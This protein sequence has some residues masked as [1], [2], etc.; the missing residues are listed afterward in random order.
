MNM[1]AMHLFLA[2]GTHHGFIAGTCE[3]LA[4]LL[5]SEHGESMKDWI[6]KEVERMLNQHLTEEGYLLEPEVERH[7]RNALNALLEEEVY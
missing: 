3:T 2:V 6:F 1:A 7:I 5:L 4:R